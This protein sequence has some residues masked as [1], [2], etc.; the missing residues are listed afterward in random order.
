LGTSLRLPPQFE[1][2]RDQ[3]IAALPPLILDT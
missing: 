1:A 3:I 2:Q